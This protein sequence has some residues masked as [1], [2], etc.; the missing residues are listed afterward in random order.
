[1]TLDIS[2]TYLAT[3]EEIAEARRIMA[4]DYIEVDN[5]ARVVRDSA[6]ETVWVQAWIR[7]TE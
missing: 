4:S 7:I 1:M 2:R 3:E 5:N 6:T